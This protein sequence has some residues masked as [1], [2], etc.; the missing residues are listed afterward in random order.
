MALREQFKLKRLEIANL[1]LSSATGTKKLARPR[2]HWGGASFEPRI[3]EVDI[4]NVRVTT[5]DDYFDHHPARPVSFIKCDVECHEHDVFQG[6][7]RVLQEDRPDLLFEC[8]DAS[9][10]D[11]KVFSYLNRLDYAGFCFYQNGLSPVSE[12]PEIRHLM[13]KRARTD[14]AFVPNEAFYQ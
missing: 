3:G 14:F 8:F 11:C 13:H 4:L 5:L 1:G 10:R 12:Y 6:G 9:S 7:K 2:T